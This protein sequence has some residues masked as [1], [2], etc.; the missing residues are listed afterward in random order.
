MVRFHSGAL[1]RGKFM[2]YKCNRCDEWVKDKFIFGVLHFCLTDEEYQ[3]KLDYS[4][5]LTIQRQ[6]LLAQHSN[7][8]T[9]EELLNCDQAKFRQKNNI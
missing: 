3:Q 4:H 5:R 1:D 8:P 6:R 2:R 9:L 7:F